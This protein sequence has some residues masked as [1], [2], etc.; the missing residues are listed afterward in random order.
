MLFRS[1]EW[2]IIPLTKRAKQAQAE[3]KEKENQTS[4]TENTEPVLKEDNAAA[5]ADVKDEN[6]D[7]NN[8]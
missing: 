2:A 1:N 6:A 8:G 4:L 7:K 3:K 5:P